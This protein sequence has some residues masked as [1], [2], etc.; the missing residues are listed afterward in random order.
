MAYEILSYAGAGALR[1]GMSPEAA[2]NILGS[3]RFARIDRGRF[4]EMYG[5]GPALTYEELDQQFWLVEI[6]F[7]K[8]AGEV[9]LGKCDLFGEDSQ[10]VLRE[11]CAADPGVKE[12]AGTLVFPELGLSATGFHIGPEES[13]AVTAFARGRWDKQMSTAKAFNPG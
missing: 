13:R 8:S 9:R 12:I 7:V 3:P 4:R 6:G 11:L 5:L 1:F 10:T 2:Q